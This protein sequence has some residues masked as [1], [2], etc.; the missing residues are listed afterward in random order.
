MFVGTTTYLNQTP[1]HNKFLKTPSE[2]WL[3]PG[4]I[5]VV[6]FLY[7]SDDRGILSGRELWDGYDPMISSFLGNHS[8]REKKGL[9]V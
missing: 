8:I 4:I 2:S 3:P 6:R 1:A 9:V 5:P 7:F